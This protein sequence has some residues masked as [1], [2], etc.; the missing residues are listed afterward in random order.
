MEKFTNDMS[1]FQYCYEKDIYFIAFDVVFIS[2]K[3]SENVKQMFLSSMYL[4]VFMMPHMGSHSATVAF[5]N[6]I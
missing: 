6:H 1:E 5:L 3:E 4:N 2:F